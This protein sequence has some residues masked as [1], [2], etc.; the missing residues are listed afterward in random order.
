[1]TYQMVRW[2]DTRGVDD[3]RGPDVGQGG[4][5]FSAG[6]AVGEGF[7]GGDVEVGDDGVAFAVGH[8]DEDAAFHRHDKAGVGDDVG[9]SAGSN[10]PEGPKGFASEGVA[11]VVGDHARSVAFDRPETQDDATG[12]SEASADAHGGRPQG[13]SPAIVDSFCARTGF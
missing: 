3:S 10:Y 7:D 8:G 12:C 4:L 5:P 9:F 11:D 1:M 2:Q 13:R 6:F